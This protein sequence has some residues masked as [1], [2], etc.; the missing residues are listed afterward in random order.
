[1]KRI[2]DTLF[3][4]R[5]ETVF[6]D[7]R[8]TRTRKYQQRKPYLPIHADKKQNTESRNEQYECRSQVG[9]FCDNDERDNDNDGKL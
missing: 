6:V 4:I 5:L 2:V 9:L 8:R 1:M 3:L 7:Y